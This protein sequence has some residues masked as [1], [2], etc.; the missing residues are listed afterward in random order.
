MMKK[1][2]S[3][4]LTPVLTE[5]ERVELIEELLTQM[6]IPWRYRTSDEEGGIFFTNADGVR[7]KFT[8][9][10]FVKRS[11]AIELSSID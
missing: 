3:P 4:S 2:D 8:D 10:I 6:G 11:L 9:N 1:S 5:S 7:E